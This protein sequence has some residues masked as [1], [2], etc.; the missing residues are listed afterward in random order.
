MIDKDEAAFLWHAASIAARYKSE[1]N[2]VNI[3]QRC[4]RQELTEY[5]KNF[6]E[7]GVLA[8]KLFNYLENDDGICKDMQENIINHVFD[9]MQNDAM[10]KNDKIDNI[11]DYARRAYR[12]G[13]YRALSDDLWK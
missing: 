1:Q 10:S 12:L 8:G 11:S 5:E 7:R 2:I 3:A 9:I 6:I 4:K 13:Y